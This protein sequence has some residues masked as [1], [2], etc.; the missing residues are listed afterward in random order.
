MPM[1]TA[2]AHKACAAHG[3]RK[4]IIHLVHLATA[5]IHHH[6]LHGLH[7]TGHDLPHLHQFLPELLAQSDG[8]HIILCFV[9]H[10]AYPFTG[11]GEA[12]GDLKACGPDT[13]FIRGMAM[14]FR[15]LGGFAFHLRHPA[16][17]DVH[18]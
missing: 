14:G 9:L 16:V 3:H 15:G 12:G 11:P 2:H 13:G 8:L 1:N 5:A 6:L 10:R 17:H 7:D 18:K 4:Y